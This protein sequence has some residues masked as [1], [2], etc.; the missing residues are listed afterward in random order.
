MRCLLTFCLFLAL[1]FESA[2]VKAQAVEGLTQDARGRYTYTHTSYA[3][4][5]AKEALY[6][7]L[8][9]FVVNDLNASETYIR[10]DE[11]RRD[12]V[13]TIAFFELD[14][15]PEI[16]NQVIDCKARLDF[17]A[18]S[19]TLKLTGFNYSAIVNNRA[20]GRPLN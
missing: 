18:G 10:W 15:S 4:D 16:Q 14:N 9:P 11:T 5:V 20:Y 17:T 7:R 6:A 3:P 19:V 12:S 2:I 1:V 13:V 8:Q